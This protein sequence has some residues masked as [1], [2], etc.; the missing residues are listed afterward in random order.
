M[1]PLRDTIQSRHYPVVTIGIIGINLVVYFLHPAHGPDF[2][3][4][5]YT[6]GLVPARYTMAEMARH[7]TAAQQVFAVFSFMFLHGGILHILGNMW[8]LYIFGDN[9]EDFLGSFYFALFYIAG[10][11]FSGVAHMVLNLSSTTPVIGASGAVAAVMGAY[12]ILY[13]TSRILTLFPI[14]FIPL[15]LEIPAFVFLGIW[16]MIQV[17][18]AAGTAGM[19]GPGIAW[20]AHIGGFVFGVVG[21]K[22]A[23]GAYAAAPGGERSRWGGIRK[24]KSSHLHV[25]RPISGE[26]GLDLKATLTVTPYEAHAGTTKIVNLRSGFQKQMYRVRVPG[27]MKDGSLLRLRG[28]GRKNQ[29]GEPGDLYLEVRVKEND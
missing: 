9:V 24:R 21:I 4:I 23:Q 13:P 3:E 20:W 28:L 8:I 27:G 10:G 2:Q 1:I 15:F 26:E 25:V 14:L 5:A 22:F 12:F 29:S 17:L 6:Y 19:D 18:N 16:F 11:L 7:F